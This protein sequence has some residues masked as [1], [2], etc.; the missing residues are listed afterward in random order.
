MWIYVSH[1]TIGV[2]EMV[3]STTCPW[4]KSQDTE[5]SMGLND[6]TITWKT[7][8]FDAPWKMMPFCPKSLSCGRGQSWLKN[9]WNLL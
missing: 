6:M 7:C 8:E 1:Y 3:G 5:G 9:Q 4:S 2:L